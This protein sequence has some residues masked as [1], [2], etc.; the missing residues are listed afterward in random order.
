MFKGVLL[1]TV[2]I[3]LSS[4]SQFILRIYLARV[5]TFRYLSN[6]W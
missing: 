3:R 1:S 2:I 6:L 5:S 4:G